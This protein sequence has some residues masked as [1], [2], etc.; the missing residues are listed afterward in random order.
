MNTRELFH[1]PNP[2]NE[3]AARVVAAGVLILALLTLTTRRPWLLVP[4]AY[5]FVARAL[6]GPTL[7]PLGQLSTR[8]ITPRLP[9]PPKLV[10]GPPKR[11]AQALGA[12][13][14]VSAALLALVYR[15]TTAAYTLVSLMVVFATLESAFGFCIGCKL[16]GVLIRLGL[17]PEDVCAE[18]ANIWDRPGLRDS[19]YRPD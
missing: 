19:P 1:F 14:S 5:G 4:I 11:F 3:I 7:S 2:V 17:V 15:R 16:F 12:V 13:V 9:I 10:A 18:C 8:V 6:S